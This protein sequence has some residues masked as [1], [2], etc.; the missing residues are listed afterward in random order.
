MSRNL[1][2]GLSKRKLKLPTKWVVVPSNRAKG[3]RMELATTN[4]LCKSTLAALEAWIDAELEA[5]RQET[6]QLRAENLELRHLK[7]QLEEELKA[8]EPACQT[9]K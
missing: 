5:V 4:V 2:L 6:T 7:Y 8:S 1:N 3:V 9:L